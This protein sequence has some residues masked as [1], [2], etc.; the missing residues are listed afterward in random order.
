MTQ[1]VN[2]LYLTQFGFKLPKSGETILDIH[3]QKYNYSYRVLKGLF[4]SFL[5]SQG[6]NFWEPKLII[7]ISKAQEEKYQLHLDS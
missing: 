7:Y 2:S 5:H 3:T 6:L 1:I 4:S